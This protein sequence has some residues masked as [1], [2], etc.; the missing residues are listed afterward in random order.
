[1]ETF[2]SLKHRNFKLFF[3]GQIISLPGNWI[4]SI[5][6]GWL[7]FRLTDSAFL[8]G[9]V[10]FAS[11]IPAFFITPLA[12]VFADKLERRK[13][14]LITQVVSM[15]MALFLATLIFSDNVSVPLIISAAIINGIA[16]AID[17]PFRHAFLVNMIE[18][19]TDLPNAI[20]LNSTMYNSARFIGPPIGGFLVAYAGEG[21]CF[22]VNGLSY[23][24][25]IAS[26]LSMRLVN[27][28]RK[29]DDSSVFTE[30][31]GGFKY[32][33]N[34]NH[35]KVLLILVIIVS[36]LGL[37]FQ[38]FLPVFAKVILR[39]DSQTLGI[40]TGALGAGALTGAL[41]LANKASIKR[42]PNLIFVTGL[43]FAIG[44]GTFTVSENL[45]ISLPAIMITGFGMVTLFAACNTLLQ[46]M[47]RENM[48]GR[49]V[50]LYSMSFM[51]FT[52]IGSILMGSIT[53]IAGL[54]PTLLVASILCLLISVWYYK[55]L[56]DI[57]DALAKY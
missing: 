52:P 8:L 51:G 18:D 27:Q 25:V 21:V 16:N 44:L 37:P 48:R 6:M 39:G 28:E 7:V 9:I 12:G 29:I 43:L 36:L 3:F 54:Q 42:F 13:V 17:N 56:P 41:M 30:L 26:L 38:V 15:L 57:R 20:A 50:A 55:H 23:I 11:Q 19:R 34:T 35:L 53:E 10:G 5:A 33:W 46:T 40:L 4:Q 1:M 47:V 14:L 45:F 49:I 2:K 31:I 22:L 32:A 24:A